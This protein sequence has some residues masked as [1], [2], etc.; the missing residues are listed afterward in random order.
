MEQLGSGALPPSQT[1]SSRMLHDENRAISSSSASAAA[2]M[3]S[4]AVRPSPTL[5]DGPTDRL[6]AFRPACDEIN[7]RMPLQQSIVLTSAAALSLLDG[8]IG[9]FA[10][11]S[12]AAKTTPSAWSLNLFIVSH[13]I[14]SSSEFYTW[15]EAPSL[16]LQV[17]TSDQLRARSPCRCNRWPKGRVEG[18]YLCYGYCVS[19]L[20]PFCPPLSVDA[21]SPREFL[22]SDQITSVV[23]KR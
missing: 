9:F 17:S 4:A 19:P 13:L 1:G 7:G 23:S 10:M 15:H 3:Q 22:S 5:A 6:L 11:V 14:S 16:H 18:K 2:L 20:L 8:S 21:F 12:G